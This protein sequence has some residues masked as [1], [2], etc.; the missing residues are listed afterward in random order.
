MIPQHGATAADVAESSRSHV[1]SV[2]LEGCLRADPLPSSGCHGAWTKARLRWTLAD[3]DVLENVS[4]FLVWTCCPTDSVRT[5]SGLGSNESAPAAQT[6]V[7]ERT[8]SGVAQIS[9]VREERV[10]ADELSEDDTGGFDRGSSESGGPP[11][12]IIRRDH[13]CADSGSVL[14]SADW[15]CLGLTAVTSFGVEHRNL[16]ALDCRGNFRVQPVL[17]GGIVLPHASVVIR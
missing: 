5:C 14:S 15:R 13:R 17:C 4:H 2:P 16:S 11:A 8:C 7:S 10:D 6:A 9:A 3:D 1:C 12:K